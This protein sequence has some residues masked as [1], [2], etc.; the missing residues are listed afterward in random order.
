MDHFLFEVSPF[1]MSSA[2]TF[3]LNC[4]SWMPLA[5]ASILDVFEDALETCPGYFAGMGRRLHALL[6]SA[7][8]VP[9]RDPFKMP[10][11]TMFLLLVD[12]ICLMVP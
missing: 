8:R 11:A 2:T 9:F 7:C 5:G 10:S 1:K 12:L 4:C 6:N 3:F